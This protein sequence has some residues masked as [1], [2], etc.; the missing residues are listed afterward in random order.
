LIGKT[1]IT[2]E[3]RN[4]A[5]KAGVVFFKDGEFYEETFLYIGEVV[6]DHSKKWHV[7]QLKTIWGN[8]CRGTSRLLIFSE[9]KKYIGEYSHYDAI[10]IRIENNQIIFD[11]T[12][13]SG[14]S[15]IFDE[16]G[17]PKKVR[18]NGDFLE[19]Y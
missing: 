7:A 16:E 2:S 10:P 6:Q 5:V 4:S 15:I 11:A 3:L 13:E 19:F 9:D 14:N 12:P 1:P 8:S 17:P 18:I